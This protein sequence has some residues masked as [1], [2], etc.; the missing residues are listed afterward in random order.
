MKL[1]C[2]FWQQ[3]APHKRQAT[4]LV[5]DACG[6]KKMQVSGTSA[7]MIVSLQQTHTGT[8]ELC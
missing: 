3:Q 4:P 6:W 7:H 2:F 1:C 5:C 8:S